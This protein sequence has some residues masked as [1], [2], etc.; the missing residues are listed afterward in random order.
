MI[1]GSNRAM[2]SI[3][4]SGTTNTILKNKK[5]FSQLSPVETHVN[6][7]FGISN[8]IEGSGRVCILL[9]E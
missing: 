4:D 1:E 9:S 2:T 6:T 8:L 3:R 5:Y 7:I